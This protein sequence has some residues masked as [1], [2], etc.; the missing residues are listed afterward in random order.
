MCT[1]GFRGQHLNDFEGL[2]VPHTEATLST[3]TFTFETM[4]MVL[5]ILCHRM[6]KS[7]GGD[8]EGGAPGT[9]RTAV[10][11][12]FDGGTLESLVFDLYDAE[13]EDVEWAAPNAEG[14]IVLVARRSRLLRSARTTVV[15]VTTAGTSVTPG[16]LDRLDYAREMNGADRAALVH[17]GDVPEETYDAASGTKVTI[18]DADALRARLADTDLTP[19]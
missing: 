8:A 3:H 19:P 1:T 10:L 11:E 16:S 17:P 7:D 6:A 18:V 9:W 2:S 14:S 5:A 15:A 4:F 13:G 12:S